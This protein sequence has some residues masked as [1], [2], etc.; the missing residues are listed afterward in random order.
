MNIIPNLVLVVAISALTGCAASAYK[1]LRKVRPHG[2]VSS[3]HR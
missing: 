3:T 1:P 2:Y